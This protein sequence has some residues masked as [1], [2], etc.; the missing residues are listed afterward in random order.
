MLF[1]AV[2][3][4]YHENPSIK[5][6]VDGTT[7]STMTSYALPQN[8]TFRGRR[9]TLPVATSGYV[10]HLESSSSNLLNYT[11]DTT[12]IEV[13]NEQKL[14]HY[15]E[16]GFRGAGE[17]RPTIYLD[18]EAQTENFQL[19]NNIPVTI[20]ASS[21]IETLRVYFNPLAYG[22]IPHIHNLGTST[23]DTEILWAMPVALLPRF[24]RGIR[25]HSEF[26]ITYKGD[27][28]IQWYLDGVSKGT[29]N[30]NSSEVVG[31]DS[32]GNDITK[33]LTKTEKAYFPSNTIGHVLQ[34]VHENPEDRGKIY[35][36][37]TD[38]TLADLEQ[39]G[40]RPQPEEG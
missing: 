21:A 12:P 25:T 35:M 18:G 9:I 6:S 5:V 10:G 39:Q 1:Q 16:L 29:Y 3:L 15:Y 38:Q 2:R 7:V 26:Q 19:V 4:E 22:Y 11:F 23:A 8:N 37:E 27:V 36:I 24:Y 34:Y 31:Q 13:F 30:F 40:M 28:S 32:N 14:F 17:L 20:T 33:Y